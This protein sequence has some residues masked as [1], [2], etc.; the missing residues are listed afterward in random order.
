MVTKFEQSFMVSG[1]Y[2][3]REA[4][5]ET[6][7]SQLRQLGSKWECYEPDDAGDFQSIYKPER[8][9]RKAF[10]NAGFA[11]SNISPISPAD[12]VIREEFRAVGSYHAKPRIM[13]LDIETR[14]GTVMPGFPVPDKALEP[15]SLIQFL[16]SKTDVVHIIGDKE[17]YFQKYWDAQADHKG[18]EIKYLSCKTEIEMF[19]K[20]FAFI[21]EMKP[22]VVFAWNGEGFDFPYLFNRAERLNLNVNK[23]SPWRSHFG[24]EIAKLKAG[25][26]AQNKYYANIEAAGVYY[27][28]MLK[29]YKK[30]VLAPRTS[31]SLMNIATVEL[32]A[33]K[34]EHAEFRT[35]DDFYQGNYRKPENPTPEQADTLCYK[36]SEKGVSYDQI[37]KAG[38]SQFVY[39]GVIDVVLLQG[40]DQKAGL[41]KL[42]VAISEKMTCQFDGVLRTTGPWASRIRNTLYDQKIIINPKDLPADLEKKIE[43]GYVRQPET[44]KQR[45]VLSADVNSMYPILAMAG[46]NISPD[47]FKFAWEVLP[48]LKDFVIKEL[49]VGTDQEQNEENL[50][51][52]IKDPQKTAKLQAMLEM[53]N[54]TMAPNGT[55]FDRSKEGIIRQLVIGI[56]KERKVRKKEMLKAEQAKNDV[57]AEIRRRLAAGSVGV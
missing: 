18:K 48:E 37:Q 51:D 52:L 7:S 30:I 25:W 34:I 55:F 16:D 14:V 47:T 15:V 42:M 11:R 43:G 32:K 57:Q 10:G 35:F 5:P 26:D 29:L 23:F 53:T 50:L 54:L 28:D 4:D 39:Y 24:G 40:I 46:S 8:R 27:I 41:S 44:G 6:G 36:L 38:Y 13:Y 45:W 33:R 21:E 20:F 17:F 2:Y 12:L 22:A 1:R 31:Y 9:F 49:K 3:V 19:E 56:Y